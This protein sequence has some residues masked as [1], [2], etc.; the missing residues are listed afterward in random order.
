MT[1]SPLPVPFPNS[2]WVLPAQFLAGE[3]PGELD[4]EEFRQKLA[5]LLDA[6]IRTF[7][8]LTEPRDLGEDGGVIFGYRRLLSELAD[9]RQLEITQLTVPVRD[10]GVPSA[11]TMRCILAVIDRSLADKNP[12]YVHCLAGIGRTGTV[13]GCYLKRHGLATDDGVLDRIAELR[14][15]M[16]EDWGPSPQTPEQARM[17]QVWRE[18]D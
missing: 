13:V 12:V 16:E 18:T 17:I 15:F 14:S 1:N 4:A 11:A 3:H 10:R 5:A 6:G 2:Y 9:A 7:I 8:D